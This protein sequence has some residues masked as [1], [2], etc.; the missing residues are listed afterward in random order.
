MTEDIIL[1]NLRQKIDALRS[2]KKV[3][4]Q[5]RFMLSNKINNC[6][7]VLL[8]FPF[9]APHQDGLPEANFFL[10]KH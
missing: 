7:T 9:S 2:V 10:T 6:S 5:S 3:A 1:Y 8:T 4:P